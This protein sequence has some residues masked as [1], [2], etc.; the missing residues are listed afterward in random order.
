MQNGVI[1][2]CCDNMWCNNVVAND[3]ANQEKRQQ[4]IL[5]MWIGNDNRH[6]CSYV[7]SC[8]VWTFGN[9]FNMFLE[10]LVVGKFMTCHMSIY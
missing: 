5:L 1:W 3:D 9:C 6:P 10:M 2:R 8:F 7:I 4:Y